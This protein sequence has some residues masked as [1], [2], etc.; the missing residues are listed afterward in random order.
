MWK[1][2]VFE[3]GRVWLIA[4]FL[5]GRFTCSIRTFFYPLGLAFRKIGKGGETGKE[6][7]HGCVCILGS[8]FI[9]FPPLR[10]CLSLPVTTPNV[11][12]SIF[13]FP[14]SFSFSFHVFT[15]LL[16]VESWR[17]YSFDGNDSPF[18]VCSHYIGLIIKLFFFC[19]ECGEYE[20][21]PGMRVITFSPIFF[22]SLTTHLS[23]YQVRWNRG[24]DGDGGKWK[25]ANNEN[26]WAIWKLA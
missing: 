21:G 14:F 20:S 22:Y 5:T 11:H 7:L 13:H 25:V 12:L 3:E 18:A 19:P 8:R 26:W 16:F 24:M 17:R 6:I 2:T 10:L 4:Q 9:T 23:A 1:I 15:L